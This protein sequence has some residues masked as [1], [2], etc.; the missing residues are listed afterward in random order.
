MATKIWVGT[1][2]GNEGDWDVAANWSPSGVPVS[3]DDAFLDNTAQSV[4]AGFAQSAVALTSLTITNTFTGQIGDASTYLAIGTAALDIGIAMGSDRTTKGSNFIKIDLGSATA[5]QANIHNSNATGSD[6]NL[7]SIQLIAANA[8][9][10]IFVTGGVVGVAMAAD[11]TA[12]IGDATIS[13]RPGSETSPSL[14]LADG[15]TVTNTTIADG[16]AYL[17]SLPTT[18]TVTGGTVTT[19]GSDA[20]TTVNVKGGAGIFNA[21]GTITT[22]N[23]ELSGEA[24]FLKSSVART[25]TNCNLGVGV[26]KL[27]KDNVTLTNDIVLSKTGASS[28][29]L[30]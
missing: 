15:V 24:D 3:T 26:L 20:I 4:T 10:D 19:Q 23:I 6:A 27:N 18:L 2:V 25:V 7:P 12:T 14:S 22:L 29:S 16:V 5:C 8:S 28:I 9:T 13:T 30:T 1:D 11:D 17:S 21:S